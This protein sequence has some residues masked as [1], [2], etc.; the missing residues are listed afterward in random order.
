MI[1]TGV[2]NAVSGQE[3][4]VVSSGMLGTANEVVVAGEGEKLTD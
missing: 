3:D 2:L 4:Y 1:S